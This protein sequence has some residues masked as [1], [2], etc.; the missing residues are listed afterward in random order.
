MGMARSAETAEPETSDRDLLREARSGDRAAFGEIVLRYEDRVYGACRSLLRD[1]EDAVEAAQ[2]TFLHAFLSI[3]KLR[4]DGQLAGWLCGI[5]L[6]LCK[7]RLRRAS[8]RRRLW[9]LRPG[10]ARPCGTPEE[11]SLEES[12]RRLPEPERV[13]LGLRFHASLS[14]A[15]VAEAMGLDVPAAKRLVYQGLQH[16]RE[17][18]DQEDVR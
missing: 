8:R 10:R 14:H 3:E 4:D 15:D 5:A 18:M 7:A 9:G 16:L 1:R 6:T 11:S 17:M 13:A 12:L 2:E